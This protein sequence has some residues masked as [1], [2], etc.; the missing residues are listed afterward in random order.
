MQMK[1]Q[2]LHRHTPPDPGVEVQP[3]GTKYACVSLSRTER[4]HFPGPEPG[5]REQSGVLRLGNSDDS[6]EKE[7]PWSDKM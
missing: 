3:T 6:Q 7:M 4:P 1:P 5:V 2:Q